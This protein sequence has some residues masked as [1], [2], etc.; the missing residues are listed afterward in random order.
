MTS[1]AIF[2]AGGGAVALFA[3]I[4]VFILPGGESMLHNRLRTLGEVAPMVPKEAAAPREPA[5]RGASLWPDRR[6]DR[7]CGSPVLRPLPAVEADQGL[8]RPALPDDPSA[9]RLDEGRIHLC[10]GHRPDRQE[11]A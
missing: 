4:L 2:L 9:E 8:H 1:P 3:A 11:H 6:R 5:V 7:V 10:A